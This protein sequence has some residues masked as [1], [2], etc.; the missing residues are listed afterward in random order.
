MSSSPYYGLSLPERLSKSTASDAFSLAL[1][2][3]DTSEM[4][5]ILLSVD[6][7]LDAANATIKTLLNDPTSFQS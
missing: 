6:Y 5:R 3:K 1:Q 2:K 7:S 4:T